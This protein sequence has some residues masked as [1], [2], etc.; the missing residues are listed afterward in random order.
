M[1]ADEAAVEDTRLDLRRRVH[2]TIRKLAKTYQLLIGSASID[3]ENGMTAA[4]Q[5]LQLD[6]FTMQIDENVRNL[7]LLIREI[8]EMK[9]ADDAPREERASFEER[10]KE[11]SSAIHDCL[12]RSFQHLAELSE[13]GFQ[14]LQDASKFLR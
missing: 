10:C 13:E 9:I 8:K 1:L 5:K 4:R 6:V 7:L 3:R 12:S 14:V 2:E 11:G